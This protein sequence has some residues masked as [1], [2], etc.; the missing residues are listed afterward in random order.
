MKTTTMMMITTTTNQWGLEDFIFL[1]P[2]SSLSKLLHLIL[3]YQYLWYS[4]TLQEIN[5]KCILQL[6]F[7]IHTGIRPIL[8]AAEVWEA[9][10]RGIGMYISWTMNEQYI[11]PRDAQS[12]LGLGLGYWGVF[13]RLG[14]GRRAWSQGW[15]AAVVFAGR[16]FTVICSSSMLECPL[17]LSR[18]R[19][20]FIDFVVLRHCNVLFRKKAYFGEKSNVLRQKSKPD[21]IWEGRLTYRDRPKAVLI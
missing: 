6:Y 2:S 8:S 10:L 3:L 1:D 18:K 4:Y 12:I 9:V 13:G 15:D 16:N 7:L 17:K 20:T 11:I 19:R 21:I 5:N 14:L